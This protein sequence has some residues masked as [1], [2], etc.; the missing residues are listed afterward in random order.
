M[1]YTDTV[2]QQEAKLGLKLT[3]KMEIHKAESTDTFFELVFSMKAALNV[4]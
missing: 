1:T 2:T 3:L 4:L